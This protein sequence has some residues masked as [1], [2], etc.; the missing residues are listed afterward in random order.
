MKVIGITGGVGAGKTQVLRYLQERTDCRIIMADQMAHKLEEPG[1][2][3]YEQIVALLGDGILSADSRIDKA[4]MA[5][6]IFGDRKV[7]AQVNAI[8]HPAVKTCITGII[9]E[10]RMAGRPAY[11]FIEAALLIED[12]YGQ[13]VDELWYIHADAAVRR[14]R[15]KADRGYDDG[16]IERIMRGQ[17]PEETFYR[18]CSAVIENNG[19]LEQVYRQIEEKLEEDSCQKQ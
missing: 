12:G 1:E 5:E 17:L 14:E 2:A 9:E 16:K 13:I 6:R 4:R 15:L 18:H 8:V 7:L 19:T 10:A 3:C 11:L